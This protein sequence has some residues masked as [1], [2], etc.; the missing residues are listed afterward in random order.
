MELPNAPN[1]PKGG[2]KMRKTQQSL[3]EDEQ[4]K[5]RRDGLQRACSHRFLDNSWSVGLQHNFP[6]YLTRGLCLQCGLV[7]HPKHWACGGPNKAVLEEAHLL[8]PVVIALDTRDHALAVINDAESHGFDQLRWMQGFIFP[9]S[10]GDLALIYSR[11]R[12]EVYQ[13]C[14]TDTALYKGTKV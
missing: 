11:A 5:M 10:Y 7:I 4:V 1:Y 3:S 2:L 13:Q 6:D 14:E 8:Y 12:I 9:N